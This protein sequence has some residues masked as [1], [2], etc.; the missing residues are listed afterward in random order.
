[1]I[2]VFLQFIL[3]CAIIA[4]PFL[5]VCGVYR[6]LT[7][8]GAHSIRR[9]VLLSALFLFGWLAV[10]IYLGSL[11]LSDPHSAN[12]FPTSGLAIFGPVI[13]GWILMFQSKTLQE[14]VHAVPQSWLIGVQF[15][16]IM[17]VIFLILYAESLMPGTFAIPA[18]CGDIIIG[19]SAIAIAAIAPKNYAYRLVAL[20]NGLGILDLVIAVGTGFLTAPSRYQIFSR[21]AP[22]VLIGTFPLVMIPIYLVPLSILL[23]LASLSKLKSTQGVTS[24]TREAAKPER[25]TV[26]K[27]RKRWTPEF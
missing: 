20:W 9:P 21:E 16:R 10:A 27:A 8:T 17:G 19:L 25:L 23:H 7:Q 13:L 14:I 24:E 1:M 2:P 3:I 18:G 5:I 15:Y 12:P 11:A 4:I 22:N 6:A 26:G